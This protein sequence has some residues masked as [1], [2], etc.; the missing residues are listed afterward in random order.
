MPVQQKYAPPTSA[1]M[2]NSTFGRH[3]NIIAIFK[4]IISLLLCFGDDVMVQE[5]CGH[6]DSK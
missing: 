2:M 6:F 4:R 3:V 5:H 1:F